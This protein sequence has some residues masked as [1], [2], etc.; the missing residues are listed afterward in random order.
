MPKANPDGTIDV[1]VALMIKVHPEEWAE[2][3]MGGNRS[4]LQTAVR[5]DVKRWVRD[6]VDTA[7]VVTEG[8]VPIQD[9]AA[10]GVY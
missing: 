7:Q 2:K 1:A 3:M 8:D 9:V 5:S 6:Y 10:R 4:T